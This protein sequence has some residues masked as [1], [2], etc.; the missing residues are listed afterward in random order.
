MSKRKTNQK[1]TMKKNKNLK[2]MKL[3][4]LNGKGK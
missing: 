3:S 2:E 1:K 4:K